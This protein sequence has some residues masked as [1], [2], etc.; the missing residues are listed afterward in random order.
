MLHARFVALDD[1]GVVLGEVA[2]VLA[3]FME[4]DRREESGFV[5]E[6]EVERGFG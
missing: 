6:V 1:D 3:N 5:G 2:G 4:D